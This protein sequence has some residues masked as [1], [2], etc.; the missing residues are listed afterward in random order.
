MTTWDEVLHKFT[1]M[2]ATFAEVKARRV[3]LEK[4]IDSIRAEEFLSARAHGRTV[5]D[6]E[7]AAKSAEAYRDAVN[8]LVAAVEAE[9][10]ARLRLEAYRVWFEM[11][12]TDAA[13]RRAEIQ[14]AR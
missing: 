10:K 13:D 11:T 9:E 1:Q 14:L 12:R 3:Q 8:D 2:G 5:A 6:A 7:A 4:V